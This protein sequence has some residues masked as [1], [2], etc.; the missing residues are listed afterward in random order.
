MKPA[1]FLLA[2][3]LL[4]ATP[5]AATAQSGHAPAPRADCPV[6]AVARGAGH[7]PQRETADVI[8]D[9]SGRAKV[10]HGA[11]Y[12]SAQSVHRKRPLLVDVRNPDDFSAYW[13]PGSLNISLYALK[14]Q[15]FLRRTPFVITGSGRTSK[16]LEQAC[17]EL[18]KQGYKVSVLRGGLDAWRSRNYPLDGNGA[19]QNDLNKM[20]PA[21]WFE[22]RLYQGWQVLVVGR[23]GGLTESARLFPGKVTVG[24]SLTKATFLA[25]FRRVLLRK[26]ASEMSRIL[27]VSETGADY[28]KFEA[29]IGQ[30]GGAK[31]F[32][33]KGGLQGYATFVNAQVAMI[34]RIEHPPKP[35]KGCGPS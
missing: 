25:A 7:I 32:Y 13:I 15:A 35:K 6:P 1:S 2:L 10:H 26:P 21:E 5:L 18:R 4:A 22:E 33:L 24:M 3:N 28:P 11:C 30:L 29:W 34:D 16:A 31:V 9:S 19:A 17:V 20:S 8:A 14:T 23:A 12:V 27:I